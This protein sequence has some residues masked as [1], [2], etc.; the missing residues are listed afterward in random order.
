MKS[1][2][3]LIIC[4]IVLAAVGGSAIIKAMEKEETTEKSDLNKAFL[5]AVKKNDARA[6]LQ[7]L[8][9]KGPRPDVN[10]TDENGDTPLHLAVQNDNLAMV[11]FLLNNGAKVGTKNKKGKLPIS[12]AMF[13]DNANE[14][15]ELLKMAKMREPNPERKAFMDIIKD[16]APTLYEAIVA[17]DPTGADHIIE[18]DR[19]GYT[20]VAGVRVSEKDGLPAIGFGPG[21]T[22]VPLERKRAVIAHELGHYALRHL[23]KRPTIKLKALEEAP[24]GKRVLKIKGKPVE[25]GGELPVSGFLSLESTVEANLQRAFSR[26]QEYEADRF[27]VIEFGI[28]IDDMIAEFK[29]PLPIGTKE[30]ET[31]KS[32][33]PLSMARIKQLEDLR[34]EVELNKIHNKQ[35]MPIDW[36]A[37]AAE[38]F[39]EWDSKKLIK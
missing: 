34:R 12:L 31:F 20:S 7:L 9:S 2:M 17:V 13:G 22:Q 27:A 23:F 14:I 6:V 32:S 26:Q 18:D 28:P 3:R 16:L 37:L 36:K 30:E 33:H 25:V 11:K 15:I 1:Y 21:T 4:A 10:A 39:K 8:G 19:F 35:P 5:D 29:A 38:Y 24:K